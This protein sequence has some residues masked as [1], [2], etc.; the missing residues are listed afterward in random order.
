MQPGGP[1][2]HY[3][4]VRNRSICFLLLVFCR[5]LSHGLV[6]FGLV[7]V[8]G[9]QLVAAVVLVEMGCFEL[10]HWFGLGFG[11]STCAREFLQE[12]E[13]L[14]LLPKISGDCLVF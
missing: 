4:Q 9:I 1:Q 11:L 3:Q 2:H 7:S 12:S 5:R 13:L 6:W 8:D 10:I 14:L